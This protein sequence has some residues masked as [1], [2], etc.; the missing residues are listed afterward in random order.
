[1]QP[2]ADKSHLLSIVAFAFGFTL[3]TDSYLPQ[4]EIELSRDRNPFYARG[5]NRLDQ[6]IK[7]HDEN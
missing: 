2:F 1:M 3:I 7:L 5:Q 6:L 4:F